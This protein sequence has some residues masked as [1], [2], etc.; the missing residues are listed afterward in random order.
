MADSFL[1]ASGNA[2]AAVA[3]A[4]AVAAVERFWHMAASTAVWGAGLRAALAVAAAGGQET[5]D[6]VQPAPLTASAA[7]AAAGEEAGG[8][9]AW[10]RD[11]PAAR[12]RV[13]ECVAAAAERLLVQGV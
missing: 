8:V 9:L 13:V 7:A 2:F 12:E 10:L 4:P 3:P 5:G 6:E 11:D 1:V